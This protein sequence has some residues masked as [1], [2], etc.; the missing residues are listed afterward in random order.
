MAT[1]GG[2]SHATDSRKGW[3][4]GA[5]WALFL[6]PLVGGCADPK[7]NSQKASLTSGWSWAPAPA[8]H[9][10][11]GRPPPRQESGD[12]SVASQPPAQS[13]HSLVMCP[14]GWR[15]PGP[16]AEGGQEDPR[17]DPGESQHCGE[18]RRRPCT[19]LLHMARVP[20]A[21]H[22]AVGVR[23][24]PAEREWPRL[25]P[26]PVELEQ[27]MSLLGPEV[28]IC[29]VKT[30][31]FLFTLSIPCLPCWSSLTLVAGGC[32]PLARGQELVEGE[33]LG[34]D[35]GRQD[36]QTHSPLLLEMPPGPRASLLPGLQRSC[37]AEPCGLSRPCVL[38]LGAC[39]LPIAGAESRLPIPELGLRHRLR[40]ARHALQSRKLPSALP[41]LLPSLLGMLL[42]GWAWGK[43]RPSRAPLARPV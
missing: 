15:L 3:E 30:L 24:A 21:T 4:A 36:L 10:S 22:S 6:C 14:L 25:C 40:A 17:G 16:G 37:S 28:T 38:L 29:R 9:Q 12:T 32:W 31:G 18:S 33:T 19:G 41:V 11:G 23:V 42:P 8:S 20:G 2:P 43:Q 26:P 39:S 7:Q 35:V 1:S 34:W 13:L 27:V 5:P